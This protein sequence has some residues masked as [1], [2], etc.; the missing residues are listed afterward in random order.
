[1][2]LLLWR[3]VIQAYRKRSKIEKTSPTQLYRKAIESYITRVDPPMSD[4]IMT[5]EHGPS[6]KKA[7]PIT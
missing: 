2:C 6:P 3:D 4:R 7:R 1:M 5:L